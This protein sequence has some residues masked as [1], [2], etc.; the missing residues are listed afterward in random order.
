MKRQ[1]K[2]CRRNGLSWRISERDGRSSFFCHVM[3]QNA[4]ELIVTTGKLDGKRSRG[5]L[6]DNLTTCSWCLRIEQWHWHVFRAGIGG[7][8]SSLMP[9]GMTLVVVVVVVVVD[10]DDDDDDDD[11]GDDDD[12]EYLQGQEHC[13]SQTLPSLCL[14][15]TSSLS[16]RALYPWHSACMDSQRHHNI[17][18]L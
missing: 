9:W 17:I 10:D 1:W 6:L 16:P 11:N 3:R 4:M 8:P 14:P 15:L 2:G 18:P 13:S 7:G 5:R 12:D